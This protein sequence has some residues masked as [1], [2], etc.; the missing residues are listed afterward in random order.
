MKI[1]NRRRNL[2]T[3]VLPVFLMFNGCSTQISE[4]TAE[5]KEKPALE[6]IDDDS[7]D[8]FREAEQKLQVQEETKAE[9]FQI[10]EVNTEK[11]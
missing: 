3:A 11:K 7:G 10:S 2:L 1:Q 4:S 8:L 6:V 5:E 9:L